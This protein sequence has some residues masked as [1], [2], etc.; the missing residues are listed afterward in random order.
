MLKAGGCVK[1]RKKNK[2]IIGSQTAPRVTPEAKA[3]HRGD[4]NTYAISIL[5]VITQYLGNDVCVCIRCMYGCMCGLY[6]IRMV[7]MYG[8]FLR[9]TRLFLDCRGLSRVLQGP[10]R[11]EKCQS[12]QQASS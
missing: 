9:L 1:S 2:R 5:C 3:R 4:W 6:G 12:M 10:R 11:G 8:S 7:V